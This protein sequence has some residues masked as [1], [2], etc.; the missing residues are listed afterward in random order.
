MLLKRFVKGKSSGKHGGVSTR[1]EIHQDN[2]NR[3]SVVKAE[4]RDN[5]VQF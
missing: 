2:I 3:I 1:V 5:V 4:N